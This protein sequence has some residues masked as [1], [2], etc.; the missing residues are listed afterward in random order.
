MVCKKT[1]PDL[2]RAHD[3]VKGG[4]L[5][6]PYVPSHLLHSPVDPTTPSPSDLSRPN[7]VRLG[8]TGRE[9]TDPRL[10]AP[11]VGPV[12]RPV[13]V[14]EGETETPTPTTGVGLVRPGG[15]RGLVM[16]TRRVQSGPEPRGNR[17]GTRE[18]Y[19]GRKGVCNPGWGGDLEQDRVR[20]WCP[21]RF[22]GGTPTHPLF[23][24]DHS[25]GRV[26]SLSERIPQVPTGRHLPLERPHRGETSST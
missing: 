10:L 7:K 5:R 11:V 15:L 23:D 6:I 13:G 3:Q 14:T 18:R 26:V 21:R 12:P 9:W 20:I 2:P 17:G 22:E 4:P 1:L 25:R 24:F 16:P 19:S 8:T